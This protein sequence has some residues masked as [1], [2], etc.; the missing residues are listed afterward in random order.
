MI[1]PRAEAWLIDLLKQPTCLVCVGNLLRHDD[2]VGPWI[3]GAVREAAAGSDVRVLDAQDVPE[4]FVPA[5]ARDDCH[6]VVFIDAV[7]A[8]GP[9][10]TLV[11]GPLAD[12]AEAPSLSTH[13]LALALSAKVLESAGKKVLLLGIV[14]AD[15]SFGEGLT[16]EVA[17]V[18][19]SLRDL[20]RR[21]LRS[22]SY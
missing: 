19:E 5:V 8:A 17:R 15:L 12:F 7:A 1:D 20:L 2:G 9:P 22:P 21:A 10:G 4:N 18:A 6:N 11:F 3:A 13:R 16:P 14:P